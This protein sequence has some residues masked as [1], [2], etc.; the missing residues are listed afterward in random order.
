MRILRQIHE[1]ERATHACSTAMAAHIYV[2]SRLAGGPRDYYVVLV[3]THSFWVRALIVHRVSLLSRTLR[4]RRARVVFVVYGVRHSSECE[5]RT[6][7]RQA[8]T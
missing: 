7:A 1:R 3:S 5:V 6:R 4:A 2:I 8:H